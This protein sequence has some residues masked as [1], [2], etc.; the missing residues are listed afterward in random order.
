MAE[1]DDVRADVDTAT[2]ERR[3]LDA[4]RL[5]LFSDAVVAIAIT[6]LALDLHV[7]RGTTNAEFWH[8]LSDHLNDY[9]AFLISFAVIG[10]SWMVHHRIFSHVGRVDNRLARWN[11]LWLLM[12][13]LTPFAARVLVGDQ[14]FAGRFSIYAG[15]QALA[16]AF[17]LLAVRA[18]DRRGLAREGTPRAVFTR[19]YERLATVSA[20]FAVSIPVAFFTQ[21]AYLCW[22]IIPLAP[23]V[24]NLATYLR[25][26]TRRAAT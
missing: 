23:R 1:L 17:F 10:G 3:I 9:T 21:W 13:V 4:E 14:V 26:R 12:I 2:N 20:A 5:S 18:I 22:G 16:A 15:V 6:L 24:R 11:M 25:R 19:S 8:D 7:P